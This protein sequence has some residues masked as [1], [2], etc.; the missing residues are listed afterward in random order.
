MVAP[1]PRRP[2]FDQA[3]VIKRKKFAAECPK[4]HDRVEK[5]DHA[6]RERLCNRCREWIPFEEVSE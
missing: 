4:C 2:L 6:P 3:V 1:R 5:F